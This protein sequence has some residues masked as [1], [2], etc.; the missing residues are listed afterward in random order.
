MLVDYYE[1]G[2]DDPAG[3][4]KPRVAEYA[5]KANRETDG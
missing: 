4:G 2:I 5:R 3:L 1:S